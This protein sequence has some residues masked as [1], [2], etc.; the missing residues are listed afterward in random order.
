MFDSW[1]NTASFTPSERISVLTERP[2]GRELIY[3]Q[4]VE[5][6]TDHLVG[7]EIVEKLGGFEKCTQFMKNRLPASKT[8]RSG[9]LGEVIATEYITLRTNY[10]VPFKR[11]RYKD[12]RNNPLR[13]DDVIGIREAVSYTHL[14]LP[15]ILL[16]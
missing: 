16:V 10:Q 11:L 5:T 9:D 4:L 2:G 15:T 1:F 7:L 12:D 14:T 8:A 6:V 13:G 3:D